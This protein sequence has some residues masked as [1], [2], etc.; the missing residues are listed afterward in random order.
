MW[1][2]LKPETR[3]KLRDIFSIPH[4]SHSEVVNNNFGV[5]QVISDGTTNIDLQSLTIEKMRDYL[6]TAAVNETVY[7]LFKRVVETIESTPRT[8]NISETIAGSA[9]PTNTNDL[10]ADSS[11]VGDTI[12][13]EKCGFQTASKFAMRMHVGKKHK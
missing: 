11:V 9:I 6:G 2:Q 5:S 3:Q 1:V 13:C 12:K 10:K 8:P 7:D 4:S